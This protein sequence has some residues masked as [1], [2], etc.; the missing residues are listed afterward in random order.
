[1]VSIIEITRTSNRKA[2]IFVCMV[3]LKGFGELTKYHVLALQ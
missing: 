1:L 2:D 3:I